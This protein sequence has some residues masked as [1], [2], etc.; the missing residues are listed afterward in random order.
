MR[1]TIIILA[2][3]A[4]LATP[5]LAAV[6]WTQGSVTLERAA[7]RDTVIVDGKSAWHCD[8][9]RCT[10]RLS[11]AP[12]AAGRVCRELA[13]RIGPVVAFETG[14]GALDAAALGQCNRQ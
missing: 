13:R 3:A 10:G 12:R 4:A 8:S 6:N 9:T 7:V 14:A 5:A 1:N 2:A 11:D